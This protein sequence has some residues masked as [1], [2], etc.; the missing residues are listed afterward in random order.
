MNIGHKIRHV[1]ESKNV[2]AQELG[3]LIGRTRQGIYDI[4]NGRVAVSVDQLNNIAESLK[5]PIVNFFIEDPDSYYDM[6][7]QVIPIREIL[8]HM[9][10]VHEQAKRGSGMVNLRIFRTKDGMYILESEFRELKKELGVKEIALL[11]K[12]VDESYAIVTD[13]LS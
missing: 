9:K 11:E 6:I 12:K 1:A 13:N 4:Y 7:P 3:E 5:E 10:H 2:S 8:K